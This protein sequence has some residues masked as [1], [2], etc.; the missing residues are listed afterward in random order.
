MC[1]TDLKLRFCC[2]AISVVIS[3][4]DDDEE[5]LL[6]DNQQFEPAADVESALRIIESGGQLPPREERIHPQNPFSAYS[7]L[8]IGALVLWCRR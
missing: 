6:G 4:D 5:A 3:A 8:V 2:C 1:V 7:I